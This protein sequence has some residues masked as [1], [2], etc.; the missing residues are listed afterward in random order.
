MKIFAVLLAGTAFAATPALAQSTDQPA[1]TPAPTAGT[2]GGR[3]DSAPTRTGHVEA[4]NDIVVSAP[5][6][7]DLNLLA[8]KSVVAGDELVRDLRPQIGD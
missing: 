2:A 5:F 8:G 6:V 3:N 7:R 4:D 1:D